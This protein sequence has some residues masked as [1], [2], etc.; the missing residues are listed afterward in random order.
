[1]VVILVKID[2][3]CECMQSKKAIE[4]LNIKVHIAILEGVYL[5]QVSIKL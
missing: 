3:F 4:S 2:G 1:M 5:L